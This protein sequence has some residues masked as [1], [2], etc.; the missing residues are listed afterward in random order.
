MKSVS[1]DI[2]I[3]ILRQAKIRENLG[4]IKNITSQINHALLKARNCACH[5]P[6]NDYWMEI[7]WFPWVSIGFK[8]T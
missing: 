5:S 7:T 6:I 8:Y 1:T 3:A 2:P 4:L